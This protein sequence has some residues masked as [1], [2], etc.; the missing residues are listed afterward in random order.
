MRSTKKPTD[1]NAATATTQAN[2]SMA[3]RMIDVC[4][5]LT[6]D[7]V[8]EETVVVGM[9]ARLMGGLKIDLRRPQRC[10]IVQ[11]TLV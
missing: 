2:A 8:G 6:A 3:G 9:V 7:E 1:D 10:T 4:Q 11:N 5:R